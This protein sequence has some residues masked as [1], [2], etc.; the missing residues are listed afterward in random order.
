[1][2]IGLGF[3]NV[4]IPKTWVFGNKRLNHLKACS[5]I[6]HYYFD[7]IFYLKFFSS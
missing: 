1:M 3:S 7:V 2:N 4:P 6:D 5:I